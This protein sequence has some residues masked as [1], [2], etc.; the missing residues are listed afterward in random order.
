MGRQ[1][2]ARRCGGAARIGGGRGIRAES[3]ASRSTPEDSRDARSS[4]AR[5]GGEGGIRTP[6]AVSRTAVFKTA[7]F[8]HSHT[9][10][11]VT[12][13]ALPPDPRLA[14]SF[15]SPLHENV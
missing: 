7:C 11:L 6:G 5:T 10:P 9:S 2:G 3:G 15:D 13:G 8:N 1:A 12:P 4:D 14:L